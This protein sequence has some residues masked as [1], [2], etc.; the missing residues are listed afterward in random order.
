[1]IS[2][3]GIPVD[4]PPAAV[5]ARVRECL[6]FSWAPPWD[7]RAG[8]R[9]G[10]L[11][12]N[13][14]DWPMWGASRWA[15]CHLIVSDP[16]LAQI[17]QRVYAGGAPSAQDLVIDDGRFYLAAAMWVLPP[18]PLSQIAGAPGFSLVSL[19]DSRYLWWDEASEVTV[20]PTVTTWLGLFAA[21]GEALGE[22]II[23]TDPVPA[24]Y[25]LP[26]ADLGT[27]FGRLPPLLDAAAASVG[28]RVTRGYDGTVRVM[29]PATARGV[30]AANLAGAVPRRAGGVAVGG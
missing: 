5:L 28:M 16:A 1:V 8:S 17:R 3:A 13:V 6:D 24:A 22:E 11:E 14:L 27:S 2:F 15:S 18:R 9:P 7:P 19:V 23:L 20:T 21:L 4:H 10:P 29:G 25:P 12:V 26:P 30:L